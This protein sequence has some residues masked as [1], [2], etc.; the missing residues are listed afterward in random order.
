MAESTL[1]TLHRQL[2]QLD[3]VKSIMFSTCHQLL[4]VSMPIFHGKT[5]HSRA[6]LAARRA[7]IRRLRGGG[8]LDF[9]L[10]FFRLSRRAREQCLDLIAGE[11]AAL[12]EC[13]SDGLYG[14]PVL[15]HQPLRCLPEDRD[16]FLAD[17]A[18]LGVK[19]AQLQ[20]AAVCVEPS[21]AAACVVNPLGRLRG[22]LRRTRALRQPPRPSQPTAGKR[23]S[24]RRVF[25]RQ[26]G[27]HSRL[28]S[29]SAAS[30]SSPARLQIA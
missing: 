9:H 30:A 27:G 13:A 17:G 1:S 23:L 19:L 25:R 3:L 5:T 18:L 10:D 8:E 29:R 11:H 20:A 24:Q 21:S 2:W 16:E 4:G 6:F 26:V 28:P 12:G 22:R 15:S 7:S 14:R